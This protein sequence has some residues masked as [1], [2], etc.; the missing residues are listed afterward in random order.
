MTKLPRKVD[1]F[2][3][4]F[5]GTLAKLNIDFPAMRDRIPTLLRSYGVDP[6]GLGKLLVLEMIDAGSRI[7]AKDRPD[8]ATEFTERANAVIY[9]IEMDG[10]RKGNLFDGIDDVLGEL[11]YRGKK[12]GVVTRNCLDAVRKLYPHIDTF[13]DIIV[14]RE[15]RTKPKP[16]PEHLETALTKLGSSPQTSVMIG[17]HPMDILV[18]KRVGTHTVGVLTGHS[19]ITLMREAGAD[20]IIEKATDILDLVEYNHV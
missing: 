12:I 7:I 1:T 14:T 13:S 17:D 6:D 16:H 19:D 20:H 11:R 3:F 18:G 9:D 2:V 15:S 10:A 5:D 4:D 8:K